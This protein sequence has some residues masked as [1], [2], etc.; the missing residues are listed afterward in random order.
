MTTQYKLLSEIEQ[1]PSKTKGMP[2]G[3]RIN[4]V[5][6][7]INKDLT[8]IFGSVMAV[9]ALI[10]H[11][12]RDYDSTQLK[13]EPLDNETIL[14]IAATIPNLSGDDEALITFARE[15]GV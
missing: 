3:K 7:V 2:L 13:R 12:I 6:G 4:Y 1:E 8:V 15:L 10:G 11:A 9:N 5:G 14:G